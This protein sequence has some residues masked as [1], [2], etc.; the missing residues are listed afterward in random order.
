MIAFSTFFRYLTLADKFLIGIGSIS[1]I[2]AGCLMPSMSI[3]M[4][5]ITNTFD[6]DNTADEIKDT[7]G[8]LAGYISLIGL[9][10][11]IFGYMYYAFW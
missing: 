9:G 11:W 3:V 4:G 1:A 8:T 6:P 2:I 7:M 5:E 10:L